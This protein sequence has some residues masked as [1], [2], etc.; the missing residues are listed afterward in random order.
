M[1]PPV[2]DFLC[3]KIDKRHERAEVTTKTATMALF[4]KHN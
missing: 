2:K 1:Q 4:W 3:R